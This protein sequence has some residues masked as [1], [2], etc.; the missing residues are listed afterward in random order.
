M[1]TIKDSETDDLSEFADYLSEFDK[2]MSFDNEDCPVCGISIP[3]KTSTI[4]SPFVEYA[5]TKNKSE[6]VEIKKK[7][8]AL[9]IPVKVEKRLDTKIFESISYD[10]VILI[11]LRCLINLKS[12]QV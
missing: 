9:C 10:Y 5:S 1:N 12:E 11:P 3:E 8:K 2:L 6:I 7:L 4:V